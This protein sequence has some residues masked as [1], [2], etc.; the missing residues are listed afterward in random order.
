MAKK[1][2]VVGK[3]GVGHLDKVLEGEVSKFKSTKKQKK[4]AAGIMHSIMGKGK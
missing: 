3:A 1:G 2:K 4:D